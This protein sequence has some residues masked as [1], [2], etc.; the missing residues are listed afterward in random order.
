MFLDID[1]IE[2]ASDEIGLDG[3]L[4][5]DWVKW[6]ERLGL[7]SRVDENCLG[8]QSIDPASASGKRSYVMN[9]WMLP[10]PAG[11]LKTVERSLRNGVSTV[12]RFPGREQVGL[13]NVC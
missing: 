6:S 1:S 13:R 5:L 8:L 4:I 10:G 12:V 11:F 9:V 7:V 2:V 3:V